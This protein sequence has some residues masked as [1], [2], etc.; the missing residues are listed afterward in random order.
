MIP[1]GDLPACHFSSHSALVSCCM[2]IYIYTKANL[3]SWV[4]YHSIIKIIIITHLRL[5][6]SPEPR[7]YVHVLFVSQRPFWVFLERHN[8]VQNNDTILWCTLG[9]YPTPPNMGIGDVEKKTILHA[10]LVQIIR[11][12]MMSNHS[13]CHPAEL[14]VAQLLSILCHRSFCH[15]RFSSFWSIH[16]VRIMYELIIHTYKHNTLNVL[17]RT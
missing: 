10:E 13:Y 12:M 1:A 6:V 7:P 15:C 9:N 4:Q 11:E 17:V 16:C 2:C 3:I 8:T 5:S 14:G